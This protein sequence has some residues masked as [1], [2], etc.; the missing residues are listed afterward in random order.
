VPATDSLMLKATD[1][2]ARLQAEDG[3]WE[4]EDGPAR[5]GH[6]TLEALRALRLCG[7]W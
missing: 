5:D 7:K 1:R 2:L 3:R 6:V 4:S